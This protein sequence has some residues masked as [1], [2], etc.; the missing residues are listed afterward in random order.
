MGSGKKVTRNR[1]Y[2]MIE[3]E[4]DVTGYHN[5]QSARK[6]AILLCEK[7]H[8]KSVTI[9]KVNRTPFGLVRRTKDG[10]IW[11]QYKNGKLTDAVNLNSDG[12]APRKK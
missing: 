10:Y 4:K 5:I 7:L 1:H 8:K 6:S 2:Y 9:R 12:T 11:M 3:T